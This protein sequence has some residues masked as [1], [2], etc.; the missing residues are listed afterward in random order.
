MYIQSNIRDSLRLSTRSP[1]GGGLVYYTFGAKSAQPSTLTESRECYTETGGAISV[2]AGVAY[3]KNGAAF[4]SVSGT[5]VAGDYVVVRFTSS[6]LYNTPLTENISMPVG[7]LPFTILTIA[8]ITEYA[9]NPDG[10]NAL[11]PD[12]ERATLP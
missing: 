6:A 2:P 3:S 1:L 12:G 7:V 5:L 4:T 10:S 11:R 8:N 9:L